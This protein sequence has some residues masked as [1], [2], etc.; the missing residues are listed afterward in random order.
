MLD[1]CY[2]KCAGLILDLWFLP[3]CMLLEDKNLKMLTDVPNCSNMYL[4]VEGVSKVPICM[5]YICTVNVFL[6]TSF[7]A[8]RGPN[9]YSVVLQDKIIFCLI[10]SCFN[11]F[12]HIRTYCDYFETF[13]HIWNY[14]K[15]FGVLVVRSEL[16]Q[17]GLFY[18]NRIPIQA[19][20]FTLL[21]LKVVL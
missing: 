12:G 11:I 15:Y 3:T 9:S 1:F 16:K 13:G 5:R 6:P 20:V 10:L 14:L 21:F 2:H 7:A 19:N 8:P 4:Y 18:E 17:F